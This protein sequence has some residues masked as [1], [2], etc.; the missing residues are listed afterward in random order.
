MKHDIHLHAIPPKSD[1]PQV[2]M[3]RCSV[4][5]RIDPLP[6]Q[7]LVGQ[8]GTSEAEEIVCRVLEDIALRLDLL[9]LAM[10]DHSFLEIA[11][12]AR[13]V[14]Q[15]ALGIGLTDVQ[16]IAMNAAISAEQQD[17]IA[18]H[19]TIARLERSFDVAVT[20]IWNLRDSTFQV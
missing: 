6:Y 8:R 13:R 16:K 3:L 15:V 18:V 20:E 1:A 10:S 2:A 14:Q 9:Q 17:G 5:A 19:A 4:E 7:S 11:K 12:Q